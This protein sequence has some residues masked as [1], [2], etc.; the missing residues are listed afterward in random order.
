MGHIN[1]ARRVAIAKQDR[2]FAAGRIKGR[3]TRAL[4]WLYGRLTC[5]GYQPLR[6][7]RYVGYAWAGGS[8]VLFAAANPHWSGHRLNWIAPVSAPADP[9][10]L[11]RLSAN[12][13]LP[14]CPRDA[15]PYAEFFA[16][17]YALDTL[18][19]VIKLGY[20]NEWK[21]VRSAPDG[22]P[23]IGGWVTQAVVWALILFG[24]MSGLMLVAAASNLVRK[25]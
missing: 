19:P 6:L 16:P 25:D 22:N 5:Y 23:L 13:R 20:T 3:G 7:A 2:L 15:R 4:H 18:L 10:C 9:N 24:W 14:D 17:A 11:A 1:D 8:A 21:I 12:P